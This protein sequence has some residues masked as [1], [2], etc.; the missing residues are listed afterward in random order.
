[1]RGMTSY[2]AAWLNMSSH[3]GSL[4][5]GKY[6]DLIITRDDFFRVDPS[7]VGQN[8]VLA[9]ILGKLHYWYA[10]CWMNLGSLTL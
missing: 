8:K 2:G 4:E 6:A 9:T 10:R 3:I 5:V 1:M 7:L